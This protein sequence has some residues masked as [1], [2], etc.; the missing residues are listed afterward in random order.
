MTSNQNIEHIFTLL[1]QY[2]FTTNNITRLCQEHDFTQKVNNTTIEKKCKKKTIQ[3]I[4]TTKNKEYSDSQCELKDK[5]NSEVFYPKQNDKLFWCFYIL[6]N[7]MT[8]YNYTTHI[9]ETEKQ[10]KFKSAEKLREMKSILRLHKL[11][12]SDIEGELVSLTKITIKGLH[13]LCI[14]HNM[15]ITYVSGYKYYILGITNENSTYKNGMIIHNSDTSIYHNIGTLFNVSE[16]D[17]EKI[18]NTKIRIKNYNKPMLGIASYTLSDLHN[19]ANILK[20]N[21]Y[22]E[23]G[24]KKLKKHLYQDVSEKI[25]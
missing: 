23:T 12:Y 9:F 1:N 14:L 19:M 3:N 25:I 7:G 6:L 21:I 11:K 4:C 2:M 24:K 18:H 10:F 16:S 15:T 13:A 8:E 17:I 22:N 20:I 5:S